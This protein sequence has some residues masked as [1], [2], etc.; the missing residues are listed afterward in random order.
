MNRNDPKRY[1]NKRW[2][3]KRSK[4]LRRDKY[5]CQISK[6][7]GKN[8]DANTVHHIYPVE[9][10]PEYQ[11]CDW[12]LISVSNEIHNKLHDR[13]TNRLTDMGEDLKR[14]IIPPT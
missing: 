6:R 7:Y 2:E 1:K 14:R 10:Y 12:N 8:V 5:L 3:A 11:Y 13:V 4:I 9:E